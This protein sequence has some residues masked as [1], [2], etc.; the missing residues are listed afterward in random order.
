LRVGVTASLLIAAA[1]V[2]APRATAL[3]SAIPDAQ[4]ELRRGGVAFV[5]VAT[6]VTAE[7]WATFH[8]EE[9]WSGGDLPEWLEVAGTSLEKPLLTDLLT[10]IGSTDREWEGGTR[11]LVFPQRRDGRLVD[12]D[13][14][15]TT[16]WHE[17][18]ADLR[19]AS[20]HSPV[21]VAGPLAWAPLASG[22]LVLLAFPFIAVAG[23]RLRRQ[24][25]DS[26]SPW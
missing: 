7:R 16:E 21:P 14:S 25:T 23:S 13:C 8:V 17:G 3:C 18:L 19:P 24:V 5:G 12:G 15:G 11:Y 9:V 2:I 22:G 1:L 26:T 10:S 6:Y 20:A 4:A